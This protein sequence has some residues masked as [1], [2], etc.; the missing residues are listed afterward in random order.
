MWEI[1]CHA[2]RALKV[3]TSYRNY[4]LCHLGL[5]AELSN[6]HVWSWKENWKRSL[7][8]TTCCQTYF[9][10]GVLHLLLG[11]DLHIPVHTWVKKVL[12]VKV[13]CLYISTGQW[14]GLELA[15]VPPLPNLLGHAAVGRNSTP[16]KLGKD[17]ISLQICCF[18]KTCWMF[19][20]FCQAN[21][22]HIGWQE[23]QQGSPLHFMR[24]EY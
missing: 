14:D 2:Y 20:G 23:N 13:T 1:P 10:K 15:L 22:T 21:V 18:G 24:K 4:E 11:G 12:F 19:T 7:L 9:S 17:D 6:L 5:A 3:S 16:R 8:C